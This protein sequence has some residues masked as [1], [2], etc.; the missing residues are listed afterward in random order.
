[1]VEEECQTSADDRVDR[2]S[3]TVMRSRTCR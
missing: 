3:W 2:Q 1:M